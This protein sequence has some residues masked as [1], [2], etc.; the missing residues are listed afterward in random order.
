MGFLI[1]FL[2]S[3]RLAIWGAL[4]AIIIVTGV[5]AGVWRHQR[6]AAREQLMAMRSEAEL[7][8]VKAK[9][10]VLEAER[11]RVEFDGFKAWVSENPA[12][13]DPEAL[14]RWMLEAGRR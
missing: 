11:H 10:A 3:V 6:N 14:R 8:R 1:D 5:C 2:D 4:V 7:W 12:P 9:A 13:K